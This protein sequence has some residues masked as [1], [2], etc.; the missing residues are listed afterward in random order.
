VLI[1]IP[2]KVAFGP[3]VRVMMRNV[4]LLGL[5]AALALVLAWLAAALLIVRPAQTLL[6]ATRQLSEGDLSARTGMNSGAGEIVRI[7]HAFDRM[8][9]AL[10]AREDESKAAAVQLSKTNRALRALSRC[11]ETVIRA[12]TEPD[13]LQDICTI[14]VQTGG[15]RLAWVGF[16][17]H[18]ED[19]RVRPVAHAGFEQGCLES[20]NLTWADTERGR[21]PTGEAIRTGK[22]GVYNNI[23]S[24]P[25]YALW[26]DEAIARGYASSIALP[27]ILNGEPCGALTLGAEQSDAF[28]REELQLLVELANDLAYGISHIRLRVEKDQAQKALQQSEASYKELYAQSKKSEELYRSFIDAS[29]D[30]IVIYDLQ[31]RAQ[32]ISPMFT[33]LFGWPL[34]EVKDKRIPFVP[35]AEKP[36][37]CNKSGRSLKTGHPV[38]VLKPGAAPNAAVSWMSV[39]ARQDTM[40]TRVSPPAWLPS[41]ATFL[42]EKGWKNTWCRPRRWKPS[43]PWPVASPTTLTTSCPL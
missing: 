23:Q 21:S 3:A 18:N 1:G 2:E 6:T 33:T 41:C 20:L 32:Y 30:A 38:P 34:D 43:A 10:K 28:D 40:I 26:R 36:V 15:Y 7:A 37:T 31:G 11:N 8:A 14:L 5:G 9:D 35:D 19:K 12:T 24:D 27:L 13:L 22:P 42:K 25:G 39:S 17:E 4:V 29:P 16:C